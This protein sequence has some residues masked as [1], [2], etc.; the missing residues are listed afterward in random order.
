MAQLENNN[1]QHSLNRT[2]NGSTSFYE[3]KRIELNDALQLA[4]RKKDIK[5]QQSI[6]RKILAIDGLRRRQIKMDRRS[7][8]TAAVFSD[9]GNYMQIM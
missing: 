3:R 2:V 9:Q 4:R 8:N 6:K 7:H 1:K 5:A